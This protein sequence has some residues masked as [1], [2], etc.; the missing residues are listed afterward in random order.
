MAKKNTL[1]ERLKE[2][3]D[4]HAKGVL[5]DEEYRTRR[6]AVMSAPDAMII[7]KKGGFPFFRVGCL[8]VIVLVVI[9]IIAAAAG[10]S[11]GDDDQKSAAAAAAANGGTPQVGT[12]KGDVHVAFGPNAN[13]VIYP[14]GNPDKK[15]KVTVLQSLDS[16]P[17]NN[18]FSKP[19]AGKK[20]WGMEVVVENV[21]T[22][23]INGLDWKLRD[24]KDI[25]HDEAIL[26][27]AAGQELQPLFN[28]TP[29]GKT[30][31]WVYFEIDAGAGPKWIRAD[32]NPFLKNDL[33]FDIK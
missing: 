15:T 24:S 11:G 22:A 33:Y 7:E 5:N 29:G 2:V 23:E 31:G 28:L 3:D 32:P 27:T 26:V 25:E 8:G 12:N 19:A 17:S 14:D 20:W 21:G 4:L 9:V 30:Q 10:S 16:V 18:Q 6:A 1:E 13:G